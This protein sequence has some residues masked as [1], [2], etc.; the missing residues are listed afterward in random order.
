[1]IRHYVVQALRVVRK[2]RLYAAINVLGLSVALAVTT[3]IVLFVADEFSYDGWHEHLD[4]IVRVDDVDFEPDGSI[5]EQQPQHP[6]PFA[7]AF[8]REHADVEATVRFSDSQ[9]VVRVEGVMHQQPVLWADDTFFDV[10]TYQAASGVLPSALKDLGSVVLTTEAADRFFGR[11]DVVGETLEIRFQESYETATVSAVVYPAP[12]GTHLPFEV[13]LPFE[14]TPL[15][16]DWI[17]SRVDNWRSSSFP[18]YALLKEGTDLQAAQTRAAGLWT[19]FYPDRA[20]RGREVGWWTGEGDPSGIAL[21]PLKELHLRS[22]VRAAFV[23]TSDPRYSW[24]LLGIAGLVLLLACINFTLIAIGQSATRASEIGVRKALGARRAE[25]AAQF[26]GEAVFMAALGLVG[27]LVLAQAL[28]PAASQLSGKE[29]HLDLLARPW[30]LGA[31]VG[32]AGLTG[33]AAGFYPSLVVSR[34]RPVEALRGRFRISGGNTLSRGL[35]LVQFAASVALVS[36][37]LV[38]QAQL[39]FLQDRD[40]GYDAEQVFVLP[41]SGLDE[42][43]LRDHLRNTLETRS[44]VEGVA[45]ISLSLNRGS[46]SSSWMVDG[47]E[48]R[49]YEYAIDAWLTDLLQM[50]LVA[51]RGF[52]AA[53]SADSSSAL[54]NEAFAADW[55]WT[56]EEALGKRIVGQEGDPEIIGVL[57]D[58]NFRSLHSDVEP[59]MFFMAGEWMAYVLVRPAAGRVQ[60]AI[61]SAE[62]AWQAFAPEVPFTYTFL[63]ED[64]ARAYENDERWSQMVQASA[65]IALLVACLG[66]FGMA[67]LTVTRRSKEIG[68]RKVLGATVPGLAGL[69]S[70]EFAVLVAI[71]TLLAAPAAWLALSGW[72]D[73]FAYRVNL[74]PWQF[75]IAGS[76]VL[77]VALSTV[78]YHAL[79][80]ALAD[81][82]KSLRYE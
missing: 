81:P 71:A 9:V 77:L 21:T 37:A 10:F 4:R 69:V 47:V 20:Q 18:V 79:R 56:A 44:D 6:Y 11:T 43:A 74:T 76:L 1:M 59:T 70:R 66:L 63:D 39:R 55:G 68:I 3:L 61:A 28:A 57:R 73:G 35:L 27:G 30:L 24:I 17:A 46:S 15:V 40:L 38:M 36:G 32:V 64:V 58:S 65:L 8:A 72:L 62:G 31:M 5:A 52:D 25:I 82:V 50:E 19:T 49:A 60:D 53:R 26:G 34:H 14:R 16:Y 45:G 22:D 75:A 29:L 80:S 67:S 41:T 33:L 54:I 23:P 12:A 42:F 48:K 78:S 13:L 2:Q 7:E 51:G